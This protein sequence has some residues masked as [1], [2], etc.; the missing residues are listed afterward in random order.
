MDIGIPHTFQGA[1]EAPSPWEEEV[2]AAESQPSYCTVQ[3]SAASQPT[4]REP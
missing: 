3:Y 2:R 1:R 4:R